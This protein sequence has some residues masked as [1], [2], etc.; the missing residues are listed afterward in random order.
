[1]S[2]K[3]VDGKVKP[4]ISII[5]P[6]YNM[7]DRIGRCLDSIVCQSFK[8]VEIIVV[9]DGSTDGTGDIVRGY[10][11]EDSRVRYIHQE[12]SGVSVAR[13]SGLET[14]SGENI[15]FIDADDEIEEDY[16]KNI[17]GKAVSTGADILVWGIKRRFED[18]HIEEWKPELEGSY[19]R[20]GF[21]TAFPPEQYWRHKG[22]YGFV[23]NKMVRKSIVDQNNLRFD[24]TMV[25]MEDYDFFLE[26]FAHSESF[27]CFPETGYLYNIYGSGN[28][29]GRYNDSLYSQLITVHTKCVDILKSEGGLNE[30]N[31]RLLLEAIAN[32]SLACF[33]EMRNASYSKVKTCMDFIWDNPYCI[34]A[35]KRRNTRKK[36]L[37]RLILNRNVLATLLYVSFWRPYLSLR[38]RG[39]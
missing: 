23:S 18:G 19:D 12:N 25:L 20:K 26:C 27:H 1:M 39:K 33:L 5:I 34:P 28:G 29:S 37:K 30:R 11:S 17:A 35:V 7:V 38:L 21:F 36:T 3:V 15:L 14:A 8:D 2:D 13:N 6:V 24:E 4:F 22:L 32:L 10:A 9:D 16:L 31:E